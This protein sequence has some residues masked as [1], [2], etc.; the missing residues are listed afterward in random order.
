MAKRVRL[1]PVAQPV[2]R[3]HPET[4]RKALYV[5]EMLTSKFVGMTEEESQ[6][7][8]EYLFKVSTRPEFV[9]RHQWRRHDLLMW[10]NRC[11]MHYALADFDETQTR[12]MRRT[13]LVGQPSGHIAQDAA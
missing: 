3:I 6:P 4:G 11:M 9:Y 2:V 8:L 12:T 7:L 13:A 1:P 10:D 5:S